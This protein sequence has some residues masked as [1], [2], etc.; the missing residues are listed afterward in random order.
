MSSKTDPIAYI[1]KLKTAYAAV[2]ADILDEQGY[3][4]QTLP[5]HIHALTPKNQKIAGRAYTARAITVHDIPE[6]PYKYTIQSV[7]RMEK[8]HVFVADVGDDRTCGFWGELL[9]TA[10]MYKGVS[11]VVMTACTR[12]QWKIKDLDFPV[13]G[14]GYCAADSKGRTHIIE[15]SRPI[16]IGNV[17]IHPDDFIIGDEDGVVVIPAAVA[18]KTLEEAL[19]KVAGENTARDELAA[20]ASM[21]E[22]FRK[23]NIL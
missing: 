10:C 19:G 17:V 20:G 9:T 12:D 14:I 1:E 2:V 8:G 3:R 18:D 13:F 7:D 5:T 11:G 4:N 23:Y 6:E 16:K 21:G 22:V 15:H